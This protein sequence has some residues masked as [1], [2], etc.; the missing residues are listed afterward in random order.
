M[1]P[2]LANFLIIAGFVAAGYFLA[3]A[4]ALSQKGI[5]NISNAILYFFTPFLIVYSVSHFDFRITEILNLIGITILNIAVIFVLVLS[6][7]LCKL[8]QSGK[9][10]FLPKRRTLPAQLHFISHK[11]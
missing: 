9:I 10:A 6:S 3:K 4:G 11:T 1:M 2:P 5:D 7:I 8:S